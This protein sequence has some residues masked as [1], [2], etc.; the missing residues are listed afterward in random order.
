MFVAVNFLQLLNSLLE[1]IYDIFTITGSQLLLSGFLGYCLNFHGLTMMEP[2]CASEVIQSVGLQLWFWGQLQY[3][4]IKVF[5]S[6]EIALEEVNVSHEEREFF[7]VN[8]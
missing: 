1:V 3:I 7:S 5:G 6:P 4:S 8:W 2:G